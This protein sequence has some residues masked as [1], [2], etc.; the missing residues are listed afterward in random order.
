MAELQLGLHLFLIALNI[1]ILE[2][3]ISLSYQTSIEILKTSKIHELK[4]Y[5]QNLL[6]LNGNSIVI[7]VILIVI[8]TEKSKC[9]LLIYLYL[10][11]FFLKK[12]ST[13]LTFIGI[14]SGTSAN[15]L[16]NLTPVIILLFVLLTYVKS[17]LT[18]F[19]LIE[20]FGVLYFFIFLNN[21]KNTTITL[22]QYKNSLLL[23][24]W[25]NFF[26]TIFLSLSCLL[27]VRY[28]GTSDFDELGLVYVPTLSVYLYLIG[29][30]WKVGYPLFHF[31][32]LELYRYLIQENVLLFSIITTLVGFSLLNFLCNQSVV[33]SV[34]NQNNFLIISFCL[35]IPLVACKLKNI[36]F[37]EFLGISGVLTMATFSVVYLLN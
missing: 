5:S 22:L 31:F 13:S 32:K 28:V 37:F 25:N 9:N 19:F 30:G 1:Y 16:K 26:T 15:V 17:L 21:A 18:L 6:N 4:P 3:F 20:L 11:I 8:V 36:N 2:S 27:I 29:F 33:F 10:T 7:S 24:L 14:V 12:L 35:L 23:L 34:L